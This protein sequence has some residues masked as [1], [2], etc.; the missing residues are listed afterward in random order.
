MAGWVKSGKGTKLLKMLQKSS[1]DMLRTL[2][3]FALE[4]C[5]KIEYYVSEI[6]TY[7]SN[8]FPQ[9]YKKLP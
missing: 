6:Q 8:L 9:Q 5:K 7:G 3:I 4:I 2:Q 1:F